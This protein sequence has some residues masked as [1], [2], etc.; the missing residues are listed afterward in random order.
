MAKAQKHLAK[1]STH[2]R[3]KVSYVLRISPALTQSHLSPHPCISQNADSPKDTQSAEE[4]SEGDDDQKEKPK[5]QKGTFQNEDEP[6][7]PTN[8]GDARDVA[9]VSSFLPSFCTF[10]FRAYL[11]WFP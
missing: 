1:M 9:R 3:K 11:T 6:P 4:E 2:Q 5:G 7:Q 10:A 8:M